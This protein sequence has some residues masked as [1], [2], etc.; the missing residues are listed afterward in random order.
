MDYSRAI[1]TIRAAKKLSQ[2]EFSEIIGIDQSLVSRIESGERKPS[3]RNLEA[4]SEKLSIP[5]HLIALLASEPSDLKG[6]S[7]SEAQKLGDSL[8]KILVSS[9]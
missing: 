9:P 2:S 1:R 5:I 8:L 7:E 4:I 3:I 6:I